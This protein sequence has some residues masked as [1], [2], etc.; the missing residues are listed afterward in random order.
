MREKRKQ[1][2]GKTRNFNLSN[3]T[4]S[5]NKTNTLIENNIC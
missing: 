2:L 4:L 5:I 1:L 3:N